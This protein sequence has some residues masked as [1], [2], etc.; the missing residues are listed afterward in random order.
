MWHDVAIY[1]ELAAGSIQ[2]AIPICI[3][4][5][6]DGHISLQAREPVGPTEVLPEAIEVCILSRQW[7][8]KSSWPF[9][10]LKKLDSLGIKHS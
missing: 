3:D 5:R 4:H 9:N 1:P 8:G 10:I 2:V 6:E 7:G